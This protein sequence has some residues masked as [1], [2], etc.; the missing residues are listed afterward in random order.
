MNMTINYAEAN[1]DGGCRKQIAGYAVCVR[2]SGKTE[3]FAQTL[4]GGTT[5]P[6]AEYAGLIA[7]LKWA[8]T[9]SVRHF[10]VV[11][12]AELIVRHINGRYECKAPNLVPLYEQAQELIYGLK[13]F[14]IE[15]V[16]REFN[17]EADA[18]VNEAMDIALGKTVRQ[19]NA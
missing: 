7:A 19:Q 6:E 12:D 5:T 11:M 13:S 16:K 17:T 10:L 4:P 18:L 1:T 15:H 9:H 14:D 8:H 2:Y 3:N